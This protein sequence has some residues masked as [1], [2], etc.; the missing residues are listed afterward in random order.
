MYLASLHVF[1]DGFQNMDTFIQVPKPE[2]LQLILEW[3]KTCDHTH[4]LSNETSNS[5]L[6]N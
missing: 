5:D 4:K 6:F 1:L 2:L 3:L